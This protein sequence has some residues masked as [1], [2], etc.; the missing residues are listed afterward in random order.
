MVILRITSTHSFLKRLLDQTIFH[1][2]YDI[3]DYTIYLLSSDQ[4]L[5]IIKKYISEIGILRIT[6]ILSVLKQVFHQ[7]S[8]LLFLH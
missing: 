4:P 6:S 5:I 3:I 1:P 7:T 2:F 8:L